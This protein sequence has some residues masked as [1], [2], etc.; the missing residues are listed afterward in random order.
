M[1]LAPQIILNT[2]PTVQS[3]KS[4]SGLMAEVDLQAI[5]GL[6]LTVIANPDLKHRYG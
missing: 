1:L 2:F 5:H 6:N 3:N 4:I